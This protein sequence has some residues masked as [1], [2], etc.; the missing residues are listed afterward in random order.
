MKETIHRFILSNTTACIIIGILAMAGG[1]S[2]AYV[3]N[4]AEPWG[5]IGG[6]I[7]AFGLIFAL[8]AFG[9]RKA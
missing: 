8:Y 4:D 2:L 3:T 9:L 5:T 1:I 7:T 6:V